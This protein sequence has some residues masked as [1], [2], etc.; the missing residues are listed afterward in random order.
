MQK[1]PREG[2]SDIGNAAPA[3]SQ[4]ESQDQ[5]VARSLIQLARW[6]GRAAAHDLPFPR[7]LGGE[8]P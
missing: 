3:V 1:A 5:V 6:L 4:T 7:H 2:A 8:N